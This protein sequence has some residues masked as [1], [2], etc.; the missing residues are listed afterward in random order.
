MRERL[1]V[2]AYGRGSGNFRNVRL[3]SRV[4]AELAES[5]MRVHSFEAI[6]Q[7][8]KRGKMSASKLNPPFMI[9]TIVLNRLARH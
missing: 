4:S 1:E 2:K 9:G 8:A 3:V 7:G 5:W 6:F